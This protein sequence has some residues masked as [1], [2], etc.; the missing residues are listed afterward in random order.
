MQAPTSSE[1]TSTDNREP[2]AS[3]AVAEVRA[4]ASPASKPELGDLSSLRNSYV[5]P[6]AG[7][8]QAGGV[9]EHGCV[10]GKYRIIEPL[11]QGS[12][13]VVYRALHQTLNILVAIK[14]L[15]P[16]T[17][18]AA[19]PVLQHLRTEA[20]LLA[21]V[22]HPNVVRVWDFDDDPVLPYLVME[23]VDGLTLAE[24]I[25]QS[26]RLCLDRAVRLMIQVAE[27]LAAAHKLGVI[28]R[29]VKPSNV[30]L[31]KDG[32]AKI[33]DLGLA[34][35]HAPPD[36]AERATTA[37]GP[38]GTVA[39]MAPEQ[40]AD[41]GAVDHRAD[42]YSLGA[43]FF[44]AVTGQ[45]PFTGR[46]RNAVLLR[47]AQEQPALPRHLLVELGPAVS[48]IIL[49]MMAKDPN[50]RFQDYAEVIAAL[51]SLHA[52]VG[53]DE[54]RRRG[55]RPP[56]AGRRAAPA[57]TRPKIALAGTV[58]G[59]KRE[60][61]ATL[62]TRAVT[63]VKAGQKAAAAR[64]LRQAADLDPRNE[65]IWLWRAAIAPAPQDVL[66]FLQ[67]VLEINPTNR[68]ARVKIG[69]QQ[70][71]YISRVP[72]WECPFCGHVRAVFADRCPQ[73][74]GIRSLTKLDAILT[75]QAV[76]PAKLREAIERYDAVLWE[77]PDFATLFHR[78]LA[79]L[80]LGRYP[81]AIASLQAARGLRP[82]DAAL[83]KQVEA[84]VQRLAAPTR[85]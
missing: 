3:P 62:L 81:E 2:S 42:I 77:R 64:L 31:T 48:D 52:E 11:G 63:L 17:D 16:A 14:V 53:A 1:S 84:V 44:H 36:V 47:H 71:R 33:A 58:D 85:S 74:G 50:E 39:Y 26:G 79:Y 28:H 67:C 10:L 12:S 60:E 43:T 25:Q 65:E 40:F 35:E 9:L 56:T 38:V 18:E 61:A 23:Y 55:L 6:H 78:G 70:K 75:N 51:A 76:V 83:R 21:Q 72:I 24:L 20:R 54:P 15:R 5:R 82:Q 8:R 59:E 30:L 7:L 57:P 46:S 68:K 66:H 69:W 27:G 4:P 13:G 19:A 41:S 80:N 22:N 32:T 49:G 73:C 45:L 37:A 29:D 34:V